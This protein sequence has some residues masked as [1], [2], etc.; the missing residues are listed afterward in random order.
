MEGNIQM[1][2]EQIVEFLKS[3]AEVWNFSRL[4]KEL[5]GD[6][7]S[8]RY[9]LTEKLIE[10][11]EDSGESREQIARKVRNWLS[12]RNQ[13]SNREELFKICF[14]LEFDLER[15]EK[16]FLVSEECGI[17][18]RN[19]REL[20]Y[21][22]CLKK[23][24]S[25][26]EAQRLIR[27]LGQDMV[28]SSTLERQEMVRQCSESESISYMTISIKDEFRDV[29]SK[30]ELKRFLKENEAAFGL[31]HNTAYRKF[32]SMLDCLLN[33]VSDDHRYAD[34]PAE[35]RYS[36]S[37]VTEEYLRM[38]VP[39]QKKSGSYSKVEKL[40]K[41][42]WPSVKMVQ[43]M[44]SRK[45]DV[46]RKILLLLY[47]ATEGMGVHVPEASFV[48]EHC[49]RI[50]LMLSSCGMNLLNLHHPFDYLVVQSLYLE[51]DDDFMSWKME[52]ILKRMFQGSCRPAYL[53]VR[54]PKER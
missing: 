43:D 32:K 42:Q 13:P 20:V 21:V 46:N 30:E 27:W 33:G 40:L 28:P 18:Y 2:E 44:Y 24:Y 34:E 22:F 25:Y 48:S 54:E 50:N 53:A 26:L 5:Y 37:R 38:G 35:K 23:G 39:Y 15:A 17:H 14:A 9:M 1:K 19:P 16:L 10:Y 31:H 12:G 51:S 41:R 49:R 47:L 45:R 29:E 3:K 36:I 8:L 52:R 7:A 6:S 11:A 4:L